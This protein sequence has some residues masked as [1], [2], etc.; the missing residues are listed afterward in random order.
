MSS[1]LLVVPLHWASL[2]LGPLSEITPDLLVWV[3]SRDDYAPGD[4]DYV[5]TFRPPHGLLKA[6]PNLKLVISLGAGVDGI[7][8]DPEYPK[9]VPLVRFVDRTLSREMAQYC[10][11]HVLMHYRMQRLFDRAQGEHKWRQALLQKR[12][13]DTR[14]GILGLGEIGTLTAER[15]RDLHFDVAGWS[16]AR[17]D[18]RG[19]HSFAGP[20]EFG[21]FLNRTDVLIC[22]LPLTPETRGI[23]NARV[24][25]QLPKEA[26]VI[27]VARGGHLVD[28]D[29]IAAL[30]SGHLSG[31]TL[32]VFHTEPLPETHPFWS[33]PKVT[34]TPHIAAISEP[35][36]AAQY[37]VER[38]AR[39]ERSEALDN[40]VDPDRG[41]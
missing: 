27:N 25:A 19:V 16:R 21:A 29:L 30:D 22:L 23:L 38:I 40:I 4:I 2:W 35:R 8:A 9:E 39:F 28:E 13:E 11:L 17:R 37:V 18:V 5:L 34:V 1:L 26:F 36:V 31:A 10:V 33:H 15:L 3:D 12:A 14:I 6:L 32:D 24:F 41:Y 7:L 20:D